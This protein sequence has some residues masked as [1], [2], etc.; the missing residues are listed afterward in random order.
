M[1]GRVCYNCTLEIE[2]TGH[3]G[4]SGLTMY[5]LFSKQHPANML[6]AELACRIMLVA[7]RT[8]A[9]QLLAVELLHTRWREC[10]LRQLAPQFLSRQGLERWSLGDVSG[11][12]DVKRSRGRTEAAH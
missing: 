3:T 4:Y 1:K 12:S 5:S 11:F 9:S 10:A 8:K 7:Q 6:V 2:Y